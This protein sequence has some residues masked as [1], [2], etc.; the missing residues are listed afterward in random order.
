MTKS[1]NDNM[2]RPQLR[3][4]SGTPLHSLRAV[5]VWE[6]RSPQWGRG[7]K[8]RSGVWTGDEVPRSSNVL[9]NFKQIFSKL[10]IYILALT[11]SDRLLTLFQPFDSVSSLL[12]VFE[13]RDND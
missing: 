9:I 13:D 8:L 11:S 10:V 5:I 1:A 3:G 12:A 4:C 6:N 7:A 2:T